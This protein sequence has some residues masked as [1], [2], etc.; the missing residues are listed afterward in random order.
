MKNFIIILLSI[1]LISCKN[2]SIPFDQET[3]D[4]IN[5]FYS[6]ALEKRESY[7]LLR[8]LS[9]D[10][11]AR[12]SGSEGAKK[13]VL[14]SKKVM[15]DY[16]FD[17]VYLQEVMV[18]HWERGE[19]EE[20]Y[21]Y[22]RKDKINLSILGAGGT[23]S[24]PTEGIT[25]EVVEVASLDEVDELGRENIEGKIVF[26]N[27]AFNQRYINVGTSYGETGFQRRTG[28][29]KAAEHG[30]LA[31]VFRSLSSSTYEDFPHTGGMSY[32]EGLDSI[33]HGGLGVL[34]S[35]KLSQALKENPKL[36]LHIK[37]SGTWYPEALSHNV[38]GLL[39]GEKN[40]EKIITVGGHLDSWDIGEGAHDDGAGCVH[41]I[42]ALR[43]F[44]KQNIKPNNT[45][46]AV[47]FMNE[48]FGLRGGL[49]Y[50]E[51]AV[52][53]NEK[54]I[55]AIESDA[56]GYVPRGFGF[57]GSD[58]Q[59]EKIQDWLKYFD[60]NTISYFSKGGGGADIGPLHRQT[61][62]PMFGLSI[63]GQK[64]FEMHH[65]AKDVFELV[66]ARELELGT[67]SLASLVYLIDKYGL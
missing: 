20:A 62:T 2:E 54:H 1:C 4:V 40:P 34:S 5:T 36:K 60:K 9:K 38:V 32:K 27:K 50:A 31:S 29:V 49:K 3:S 10:I 28:A 19:L 13:A 22:N 61:G 15:E 64:Y 58:E 6:D 65:T 63:D 43:L 8:V 35:E 11:G 39:R 45:I 25:A 16:G 21:F 59:L 12:P 33:P 26:Y 42:G 37:L 17:T 24:T 23:V 18:P 51:I 14:W 66:H 44:Q 57:S 56:S 7:E 55:A 53:E 30:A 47:M 48:E 41:S 67:A 52:K 46:R